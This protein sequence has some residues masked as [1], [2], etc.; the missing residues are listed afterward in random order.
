M[1][2]ESPNQYNRRERAHGVS[3]S[4][5]GLRIV[6]V[7]Q[8]DVEMVVDDA[9][10][11]LPHEES[12]Y[13]ASEDIQMKER[14]IELK[15]V[16][17]EGHE[18]ADPS[19][20]ELLRVLG[21]GS[22]GKVFLVR[23]IV[24]KD[25]G[26]LYAM[27][28]LKKATLKVKD[29]VRST[30]ERNIL[31]DVGHAFIVKLHYAFQTPGKLY[32]ILDFLRGG[33]L[34]TRLSKEVMFTEEDVKFYLAEL[35][36]ALNHLHSIGIIY[37]DLKPENILLD[38]DGHIALTD[39]GLSKQPLDGSKTYSFCGTVEYMAP[40]VVNRKG[41]H[42]AADWWSF[43]VLMYEMLTGNLPFHGA[44]R[45]ETMN[46]ILKTKL[47]MPDNLSP[48][49]QSLLRM[50][51][52]RN[53]QNRLGAGPGGIED[54][55][56]HEFFATI[57]WDALVTKQVRP[58]FIP[59]VSRDDA[60]YFDTEY[61]SKSPRDSPGGPVSA[62]A[63]EIFRGFSFVAPG[64]L[65][66]A[67][68]PL[69][70]G[71]AG[72]VAAMQPKLPFSNEIPGVKPGAFCDEY[73]MMQ[74]LGR[75]TFSVCRLCEHKQT[76]KQY[77]A[78][79]IS[80]SGHDCREEVE[81]LLRY[82]NH[83]NIVTLFGVHE[84]NSYVYLVMELLKGGELLD[85]ILTIQ[86]MS[87]TEASAVLR[88]VVSAVAYLHEH[89]VV[90]RDLKPSNLLYASVQQTPESLKLCD[91]GFAKQL[92]A[93]N[94]LLMTP[95]Y[96][97]NFVA[98]EVLKRQGYDLACDIW[99][100]G[101]LLY[102]MLDGKTPFASTPNDSPEMILA[103]IG[104]GQIDTDSGRWKSISPEVKELLRH[105]L[106]I[107]PQKRPTAAQILRHSWLWQPP[108][109]LNRQSTD[110]Q[111]IHHQQNLATGVVPVRDHTAALR[112]AVNATF[113]AIASPQAANVGPVGMSELAK[114]RARDKSANSHV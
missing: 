93:D 101:V 111:N 98:P 44:T 56:K 6:S 48:E 62:S 5:S 96:T 24:G 38:Q 68:M 91:L 99:S 65:D 107:V 74:E 92:R 37:R 73:N 11:P 59:A 46:Q 76:R 43:G 10:D 88:T 90:H 78:K 109:D 114:R 27:K 106:H 77:A 20:F 105:M 2:M 22:F 25:A 81:I 64:L 33:D 17:K 30:N 3:N 57:D 61:T 41:H 4:I 1:E 112:G 32:L 71:S 95:C 23:K 21:E 60:F 53:P 72:A 49:A 40:E 86:R 51:F 102:I 63:H 50:L 108:P 26:T 84:D 34:F 75:G 58:P 42:F 16:V 103:R 14:E 87:E 80:K 97:A 47:G 8:E 28:V 113:R 52:K 13:V 55:K 82:G 36:L 69:S 54:I 79:I 35:A 83:P 39:F 67:G 12:H 104:S 89:G 66:D 85:R 29:R 100:L 15:D 110:V 94:G 45:Q 70:N 7:S 18:K 19:Q 31:A 9:F